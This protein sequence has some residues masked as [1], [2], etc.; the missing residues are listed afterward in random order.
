MLL[1][2]LRELEDQNVKLGSCL[3]R[4]DT[5]QALIH[6]GIIHR[7]LIETAVEVLR[8]REASPAAD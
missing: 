4:G 8:E 1:T 7:L 6:Q 5:G 3:E 2:L